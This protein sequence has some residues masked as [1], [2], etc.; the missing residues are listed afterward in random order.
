M[1]L[2]GPIRCGSCGHTSSEAANYCAAECEG[3]VVL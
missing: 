2:A 3:I 1:A